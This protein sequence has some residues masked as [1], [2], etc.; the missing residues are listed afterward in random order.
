MEKISLILLLSIAALMVSAQTVTTGSLLEEMIDREALVK[1]P[2][3]AYTVKQFSSYDRASVGP[4]ANGWFG[5]EDNN[6]FI[7]I[8]NNMGRREYVLFDA[9]GPG[10]V[11][12]FWTTVAGYSKPMFV[13]IYIDGKS[14][15]AIQGE[16]LS[17]LGNGGLVPAPLAASV[18]S[19]TV[20]EQRGNNFYL[21]VPYAQSCKITVECENEL[22]SPPSGEVLY[23]SIN[24]RTYEAGTN[25]QSFSPADLTSTYKNTLSN[26]V[27]ALRDYDRQ[28][29]ANTIA[30]QSGNVT[31]APG[32]RTSLQ[33]SGS[34]AI[35]KIQVKLSAADFPQALRSTVLSVSFD[36]E[37]RVWAPAG[38]FFGT[39]YLL[40]TYKSWYSEVSADGTMTS[41]WLMPFSE[42]C[43]VKLENAGTENVRIETFEA[44][45]VNRAWDPA[46]DMYFGAGW[47]EN[48]NMPTLDENGDHFDLN[49]VTLTGRGKLVGNGV[50]L[51]NTAEAWW[52]EGDEKIYV[53]NEI[54]PSNFGTGSEDYYGYAWCLP[55]KFYHPFIAQ[56]DGSGNFLPG[57]SVNLR[58]RSL[59][60]IPF[61]TQLQFDMEMWH[62]AYTRMNYAPVTYYYL[63]SGSSNRGINTA[64]VQKKVILNRNQLINNNVDEYG[65]VEFEN[66]PETKSGGVNNMQYDSFGLYWGDRC[67]SWWRDA[68]QNDWIEYTFVSAV[69]GNFPLEINITKA[70]DYAR[71]DV[72]FNDV[73]CTSVDAYSSFITTNRISLGG[74]WIKK[75]ENKI[76]MV[77]TGRNPSSIGNVY[78]VGFDRLLI[79]SYSNAV[80]DILPVEANVYPNPVKDKLVIEN[81]KWKMENVHI[82]NSS[83]QK[84][85]SRKF[86]AFN[87]HFSVIDV[88]SLQP[89]VYLL[90]LQTEKQICTTKLIKV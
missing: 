53:D 1:F 66:M 48:Y 41:Y 54:F 20:K 24:Y 67:Q 81:R 30:E 8:E 47:Y 19:N 32:Q 21:P 6:Q 87:A 12:R 17:Y 55:A 5:N 77:L 40:S 42:Q 60:A 82:F 7:R 80:I 16:L 58:Y 13:R 49:L 28:I 84:M 9:K 10:A 11:V 31:L 76:K 51:F 63:Q 69:E 61:S 56:P 3:P 46:R 70:N 22:V 4:G 39:G 25:V 73:K 23:Y 57:H 15:P 59:D 33:F 79:H 45:S 27:T 85:I 62:W 37:Q 65:I 64:M 14:V 72:Y 86:S 90:C 68:A 74:Q 43:T 26:V 38:D 50:T 89:G 34:K 52:G 75:G 44:L 36:G 71:F 35:R 88:S 18:A 83:G 29:P 2:S 78:M